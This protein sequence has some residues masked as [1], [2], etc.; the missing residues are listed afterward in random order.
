[1]PPLRELGRDRQTAMEKFVQNVTLQTGV[2]HRAGDH[3]AAGQCL[4]EIARGE[5]WQQVVASTDEVLAPLELRE[6][7]EKNGIEV[8]TAAD[9]PDREQYRDGVFCRAQAGITGVDCA[10]AETGTLV[11]AHDR[12]QPRLVS[13]APP[14]HVAVLPAERLFIDLESAIERVFRGENPRPPSS[15]SSAG[16]ACRRTSRPS[17]SGACTARGSFSSSWSAEGSV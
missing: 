5:G 16:R 15:P 17:A 6:W 2:V 11:L 7:G 3:R 8:R 1:V 13:L 4:G 14:T 12:D 10:L 9:Y